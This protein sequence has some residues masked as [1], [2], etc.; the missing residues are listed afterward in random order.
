MNW[1][2]PSKSGANID[3]GTVNI[4]ETKVLFP[5]FQVRKAQT[6]DV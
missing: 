4:K 1:T 3:N 5:H 2:A 6:T